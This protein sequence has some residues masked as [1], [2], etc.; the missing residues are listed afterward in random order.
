MK[1]LIDGINPLLTGKYSYSLFGSFLLIS[2]IL[3]SQFSSI[4]LA[5]KLTFPQPSDILDNGCV[6]PLENDIVW[7]F[8]WSEIP[9]ATAYH[10]Y[11]MG[12]NALN[13]VIN[14]SNL[15]STDYISKSRAYIADQ[16]RM[17]W[18][19][20]VRAM[21]NGEWG[22]WSQEQVFDVEPLNTDCLE[23]FT[24]PK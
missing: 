22:N 8:S 5:P 21:V 1:R 14:N 18:K 13:P 24:P 7:V 11:V 3:L 23:N 19:W 9:N 4:P 10:L 15:T 12:T 20:K 2:P 17:G 16:N 6:P